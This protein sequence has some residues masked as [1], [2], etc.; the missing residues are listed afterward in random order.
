MGN[1]FSLKRR[2][3]FTSGLT[4]P[5]LSA[6]RSELYSCSQTE[7]EREKK[8]SRNHK[9][10]RR[11]ELKTQQ[12]GL[13]RNTEPLQ[14]EEEG[15]RLT[16]MSARA[17]FPLYVNDNHTYFVHAVVKEGQTGVFV[18]Y[19]RAFLDEADE[20]LGFGHQGVELLVRAVTA[21]QEA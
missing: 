7:A 17:L 18:A 15:T 14:R 16:G 10:K 8:D 11:K 1:T 3:S 12:S 9:R 6:L 20:H 2:N 21:L 5:P 13:Q 19:K 4:F